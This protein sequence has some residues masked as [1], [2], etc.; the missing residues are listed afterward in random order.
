MCVILFMAT[1]IFL[2][3]L[4]SRAIGLIYRYLIPISIHE[5]TNLFV[6]W[7]NSSRSTN[8][9]IKPSCAQCFSINRGGLQVISTHTSI[10]ISLYLSWVLVEE[11]SR[12]GS[13]RRWRKRGCPSHN[14]EGKS[15]KRWKGSMR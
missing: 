4:S 11:K 2:G 9:Q 6:L 13:P 15:A 1:D 7:D 14:K 5:D 8:K 12:S 3:S 10:L